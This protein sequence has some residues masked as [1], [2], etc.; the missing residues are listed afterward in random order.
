MFD[1]IRLELTRGLSR[2]RNVP[3]ANII[4]QYARAVQLQAG[5]LPAE[6]GLAKDGGPVVTMTTIPSRL[7]AIAPTIRS[8]IDQDH[9][10]VK[11]VLAIPDHS[12]RENCGYDEAILAALPDCVSILRCQDLG[13][14]TKLLPALKAFPNQVLVVVDDDVIYPRDFLKTLWH[15]HEAHPETVLA[16]RGVN[17]CDGVAFS[18]LRHQFATSVL[19]PTPID[20][21]FGTWG[22]L[23]P[24]D[25]LDDHVHDFTGYPTQAR[26]VDD[27]WISGH[28]AKRGVP[29]LI[30]PAA[31][32]PVETLSSGRG[33]LTGGINRSGENDEIA[34]RAFDR[35]WKR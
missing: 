15:A 23:V 26:W 9:P 10:P 6:T 28:L 16:Y 8:L 12:E 3:L 5:T 32:F 34:I 4:R 24:P 11:I 31:S 19:E 2:F 14:A 7:A 25:A 13:P 22:Y 35:Y 1:R 29:R 21:V 33:S 17:L 18:D 30:V 20:I 27:V